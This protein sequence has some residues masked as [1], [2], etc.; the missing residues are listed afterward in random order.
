MNNTISD[1]ISEARKVNMLL[2][3]LQQ[4]RRNICAV[5]KRRLAIWNEKLVNKLEV[6]E[7]RTEPE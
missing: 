2:R 7:L 6:I 1:V 4:I 3:I 5:K